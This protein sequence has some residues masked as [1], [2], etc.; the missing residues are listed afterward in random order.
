MR[1]WVWQAKAR[2]TKGRMLSAV[3]QAS[4]CQ[5]LEVRP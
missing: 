4:A 5:M 2:P 1:R 3:G